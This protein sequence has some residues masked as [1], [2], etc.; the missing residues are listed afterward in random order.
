[1]TA[2]KGRTPAIIVAVVGIWFFWLF[3]AVSYVSGSLPFYGPTSGDVFRLGAFGDTF[4][5]LAS[6]MAALAA[7]AAFVAFI[8]QQEDARSQE[9]E[10]NFFTLLANLQLQVSQTDLKRF[11]RSQVQNL[12]TKLRNKDSGNRIIYDER[13][14]LPHIA[15]VRGRDAFRALLNK[16][17]RFIAS[18]ENFSD[19]KSIHRK[20]MIFYNRWYDD[21]GHY[22][23]TIYHLFKMIDEECPKDALRYV[24][25]AR[26]HI[27]NSEIILIA[28]NCS[29]GEGRQKFSKYVEKYSLLHNY[30]T[31]DS[32]DFLKRERKFF[33]RMFDPSAFGDQAAPVFEYT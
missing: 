20:Y 5:V 17:R 32:D 3:F 26:S 18:E 19:S 9:F 33:E 22:F 13:A 30:H 12:R 7:S 1:M 8:R 25:I 11:D 15:E 27:S 28:Y 23:R 31:P 14:F 16:L 10:R 24:R 21:L 4:G 2:R 29:V 6:F